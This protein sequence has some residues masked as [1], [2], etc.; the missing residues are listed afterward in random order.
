VFAC[1]FVY[2]GLGV[3]G[4]GLCSRRKQDGHACAFG[5]LMCG[6]HHAISS[7]RCLWVDLGSDKLLGLAQQ[8]SSEHCDTGRTVA[9]LVILNLGDL[10]ERAMKAGIG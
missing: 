3:G 2:V 10:C 6:T 5:A 9:N 4:G 8:L 7:N 1:L